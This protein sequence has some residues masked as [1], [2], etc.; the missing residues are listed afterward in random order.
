VVTLE[1]FNHVDHILGPHDVDRFAYY[2][3][4]KTS[5][6]NSLFADFGSEAIDCFTQL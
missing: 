6:Y 3:N 2:N 5:R 4:R 1:F